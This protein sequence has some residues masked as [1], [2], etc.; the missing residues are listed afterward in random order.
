MLPDLMKCNWQTDMEAVC[1][2][3]QQVEFNVWPSQQRV[4][5]LPDTRK[6][7]RNLAPTTRPC[8]QNA[9]LAITNKLRCRL[10]VLQISQCKFTNYHHIHP[11][12]A[13]IYKPKGRG[14]DSRWCHWIFSLTSFRPHYGPGVDSH[15]N[16]NEYQ[17]YFLGVKAAGALGSQPCHLHVP[18]VLKSGNLNLLKPSGPVKTCNGIALPS[19]YPS[20]IG[21]LMTK[22]FLQN[23]LLFKNL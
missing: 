13:L 8:F 16:R 5:V 20:S 11:I 6:H 22:Q 23:N 1:C 9:H 14:I 2:M 21:L 19:P 7:A 3:D 10:P 4:R 18:T 17:K 12:K 15:S